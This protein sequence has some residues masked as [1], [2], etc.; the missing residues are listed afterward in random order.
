[1]LDDDRAAKD[2][3][4]SATADNET[5]R[6]Q[7]QLRSSLSSYCRWGWWLYG[8]G[9]AI[10]AAAG[11]VKLS[12]ERWK[13]SDA[14][15]GDPAT[16][17]ALLAIAVVLGAFYLVRPLFGRRALAR[18]RGWVD[19][20]PFAVSG[21]FEAIENDTTEGTVT[22]F[23]Q[24]GTIAQAAT[25]DAPFRSGVASEV[26]GAPTDDLLRAVFR[27]IA[28]EVESSPG[29]SSTVKH[30]ISFGDTSVMTNVHLVDWLHRAVEVLLTLHAQHPIKSV[31]VGGFR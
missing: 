18:E 31:N 2:T 22:L 8:G 12:P 4:V 14:D 25:P 7:R 30:G 20:L 19:R 17:L 3:A 6:R 15:E 23:I 28:A 26:S 27:T 21:Y 5:R 16:A 1:M 9:L 24:F 13:S 29:G 10:A 11:V